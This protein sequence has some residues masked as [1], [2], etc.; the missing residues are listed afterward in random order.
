MSQTILYARVSTAEQNIDHQLTQAKAAGFEI[1]EVIADHGVS[2][3]SVKLKDRPEGKRL[4]DMLR[5]GDVLVV[6]WVDRLGRNYMDVTETIQKFMKRGVIIRT[7]INNLEFDGSTADPMKM[8]V[9]DAMIGF[10]AAAAQSQ[11]EATAEAR[12]AGI[13]AA[14]ERGNVYRGKKPSYD[15]AGFEAVVNMLSEGSGATV[16]AKETG[17][18]RQTVLRIRGDQAKA[19]EILERWGL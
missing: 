2:G 19:G 15:R 10:M 16:I 13:A 8:A 11:A 5:S 12:D 6:R 4:F 1:N 18:T 7:V 17:L 14:K 9:R 3:V